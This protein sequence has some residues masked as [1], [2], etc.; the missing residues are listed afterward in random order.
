MFSLVSNNHYAPAFGAVQ[1]PK[2]YQEKLLR[3]ADGFQ[4]V[5]I[6]LDE[7]YTSTHMAIQPS[8]INDL[9]DGYDFDGKIKEA[10]SKAGIP[11]DEIDIIA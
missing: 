3:W 7:S 8:Q 9:P 5:G 11:K 1:V 6:Y 2:V 4:E 10:L